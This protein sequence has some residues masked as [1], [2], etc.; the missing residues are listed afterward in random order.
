MGRLKSGKWIQE[1]IIP[2][3]SSGEFKHEEAKFREEG[4]KYPPETGMKLKRLESIMPKQES[5][6]DE[7]RVS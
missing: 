7:V 6:F 2:D 3:F 1:V 5:V 4:G